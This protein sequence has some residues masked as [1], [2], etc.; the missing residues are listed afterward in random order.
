MQLWATR[1]IK[2]QQESMLKRLGIDKE[3]GVA[4]GDSTRA[5]VESTGQAKELRAQDKLS[6]AR[7]LALRRAKQ[8]CRSRC[9]Y[10]SLPRVTQYTVQQYFCRFD[11]ALRVG[12]GGESACCCRCIPWVVLV[13]AQMSS[14]EGRGEGDSIVVD[15]PV[16]VAGGARVVAVVVVVAPCKARGN[17]T[18]HFEQWAVGTGVD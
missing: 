13:P 14:S 18:D 8:N 17:L 2:T 10:C 1:I 16:V 4:A 3:P 6:M 11:L 9:L 12:G 5:Q 7:E 15:I